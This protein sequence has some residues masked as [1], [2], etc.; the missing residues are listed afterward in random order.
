MK[1]HIVNKYCILLFSLGIDTCPNIPII[2]TRLYNMCLSIDYI[3][4]NQQCGICVP[5]FKGKYLCSQP[6]P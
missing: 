2:L 4:E 1:K 6:A 3:L 5:I